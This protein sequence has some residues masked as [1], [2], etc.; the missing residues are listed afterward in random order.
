MSI[1]GITHP[2]S[3]EQWNS[4]E[5]ALSG[6][7]ETAQAYVDIVKGN[8]ELVPVFFF[9]QRRKQPNIEN[10]RATLKRVVRRSP[11][12]GEELQSASVFESLKFADAFVEI[13]TIPHQIAT[14]VSDGM[15]EYEQL[16]PISVLMPI[17]HNE[18]TEYCTLNHSTTRNPGSIN[19]LEGGR[20][21]DQL[22]EDLVDTSFY[23]AISPSGQIFLV[24]PDHTISGNN[25]EISVASLALPIQG[26][27]NELVMSTV[28]EGLEQSDMAN[29]EAIPT[30]TGTPL[31]RF[32][33]YVKVLH[34][35]IAHRVSQIFSPTDGTRFE[36]HHATTSFGYIKANSL[37]PDQIR[38]INSRLK[39]QLEQANAGANS[40]GRKTIKI[41]VAQRKN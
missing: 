22:S 29:S 39:L 35:K 10:D 8:K 5:I 33:S 36:G 31:N 6:L 37:N 41:I 21:A 25:T 12:S 20:Y 14:G 24:F 17:F 11:S 13:N 16:H 28:V 18:T 15:Y 32:I 1:D 40:E 26:A 2:T 34:G 4:D 7:R 27:Q 9:G 30:S 38:Q 23:C 3:Q 19:Y